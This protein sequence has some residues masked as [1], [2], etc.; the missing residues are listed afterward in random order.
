MSEGQRRRQRE[1]QVNY[2]SWNDRT[3]LK[4]R[5]TMPT[6]YVGSKVSGYSYLIHFQN[7]PALDLRRTKMPKALFRLNVVLEQVHLETGKTMLTNNMTSIQESTLDV[8]GIHF[9][10]F[11]DSSSS[12][13]RYQTHTG[14]QTA[15]TQLVVK[16]S[17]QV[18]QPCCQDPNNLGESF[19]CHNKT[20]TFLFRRVWNFGW[21]HKLNKHGISATCFVA[22]FTG[23]ILR[24]YSRIAE[25][26][27]II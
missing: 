19:L 1:G 26:Q 4:Y 6:A 27:G 24:H 23:V 20:P 25:S 7:Y 10:N 8:N 22:E 5:C 12:H 15:S 16:G 2:Q 17:T 14:N 3:R 21:C 11:G 13:E 18:Y 9:C